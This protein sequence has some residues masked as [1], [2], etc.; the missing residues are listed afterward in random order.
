MGVSAFRK[1]H[2]AQDGQKP[3]DSRPN[4]P[5]SDE[6]SFTPVGFTVD[7]VESL[8]RHKILGQ[9]M[10][11]GL[12]FIQNKRPMADL[13]VKMACDLLP[14][15]VH[16]SRVR[17][18][19]GGL[20]ETIDR[21]CLKRASRATGTPNVT[22]LEC[23]AVPT[24]VPP[25]L[26]RLAVAP[27][28]RRGVWIRGHPRDLH[29]A[30]LRMF[31]TMFLFDMSA[32]DADVLRSSIPMPEELFDRMREEVR[33]GDPPEA[34]LVFTAGTD[35]ASGA[36]VPEVRNNPTLLRLRDKGRFLRP[37]DNHLRDVL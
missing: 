5:S 20:D 31:D 22:V 23:D 26:V 37:R 34:V 30:Q 32:A 21:L 15:T 2:R 35:R 24:L 18:S 29:P 25:A 16:V 19:D 9:R 12:V 1:G 11:S 8:F 17:E 36:R 10:T 33:A 13:L 28:L 3:L 6:H 27:G 14:P 4:L 7:S